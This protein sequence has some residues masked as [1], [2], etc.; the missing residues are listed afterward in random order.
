MLRTDLPK[1]ITETLPGPKAKEIIEKL[2]ETSDFYFVTSTYPD[3]VKGL[4]AE[5]NGQKLKLELTDSWHD[6][7]QAKLLYYRPCRRCYD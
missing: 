5:L 3:H 7:I 4:S 2:M 6:S 1:I